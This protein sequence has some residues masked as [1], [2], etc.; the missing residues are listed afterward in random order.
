MSRRGRVACSRR[1]PPTA[2]HWTLGASVR[3]RGA[4]LPGPALMETRLQGW[5]PARH[6]WTLRAGQRL[7]PPRHHLRLRQETRL[8]FATRRS[9][10]YTTCTESETGEVPQ[11]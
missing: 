10:S 5:I 11:L 4:R 6:W 9:F 3:S 8:R 1:P 2:A 7:P